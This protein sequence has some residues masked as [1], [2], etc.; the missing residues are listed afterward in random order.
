MPFQTIN[1]FNLQRKIPRNYLGCGKISLKIRVASFMLI[2]VS[3]KFQDIPI[4]RSIETNKILQDLEK[5]KLVLRFV[6]FLA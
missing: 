5:L 4:A 2:K 6:K 1:R 3:K